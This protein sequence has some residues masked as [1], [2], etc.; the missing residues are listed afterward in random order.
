MLT[1]YQILLAMKFRTLYTHV[2]FHACVNSENE[3]ISKNL[4]FEIPKASL[5][6][7]LQQFILVAG[8]ETFKV[9]DRTTTVDLLQDKA[10]LLS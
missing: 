5:L 9:P 3:R 4:H 2:K 10:C 8:T 7:G 6:V 1:I